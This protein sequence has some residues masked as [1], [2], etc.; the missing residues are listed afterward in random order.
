MGEMALYYYKAATASG[1]LTE[2]SFDCATESAAKSR[3]RGQG[4]MPLALDTAPLAASGAQ[5]GTSSGR[6][7]LKGGLLPRGLVGSSGERLEFTQEFST[8]LGSGVPVDQIGRAH[9]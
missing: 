9:V 2:G 6:K 1:E 7:L 3:L 8:L 5:A 4:L